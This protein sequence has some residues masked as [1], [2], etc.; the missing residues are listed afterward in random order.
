MIAG[1]VDLV[2]AGNADCQ[3]SPA[4]PDIKNL[5]NCDMSLLRHFKLGLAR[6]FVTLLIVGWSMHQVASGEEGTQADALRA[7]PFAAHNA[8]PWRLYGKDRFE[9]ALKSGLKH[10]E[11]DIT[12]DPERRAVVATHDTR[13]NGSETELRTLLEPLWSAWGANSDDGYTLII[14]MKSSSPELVRGL[15]AILEPHAKL[16]ST[17]PKA[18]G[19]F[20]PGKIT[21]CLTGSGEAHREYAAIVP[22]DGN[23]LAFGDLGFGATDWREQVADYVPKEAPGFTRFLTFEFHNFMDAPRATGAEHFSLDRLRE[24]VRLANERGYRIRVYTINPARRGDDYDTAFWDKCVQSGMHMVATDAYEPARDY[25]T[26]HVESLP[27]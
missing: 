16:L 27:K 12:Y 18:G 22:S 20:A 14:D 24:T 8:Y 21:V 9:R 15:H 6:I 2:A 7:N 1:R 19:P 4:V 26:K 17:M 25:W 3:R 5:E 13:P 23:Y 11:V 10:I